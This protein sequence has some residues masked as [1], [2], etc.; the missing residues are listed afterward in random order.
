MWCRICKSNSHL[1]TVNSKIIL[2]KKTSKCRGEL[3]LYIVPKKENPPNFVLEPIR[4]LR[5]CWN[6][7][8]SGQIIT[9]QCSALNIWNMWLDQSL[10]Y[11]CTTGVV[12]FSYITIPTHSSA[13]SSQ[14]YEDRNS[15]RWK[16]NKCTSHHNEMEYVIADKKSWIGSKLGIR[17]AG[18]VKMK[19]K[20]K[21]T[22]LN[23]HFTRCQLRN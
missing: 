8:R 13:Y 14:T 12:R 3:M 20:K 16:H 19:P 18:L 15:T 7:Q 23:K 11:V 5:A 22:K 6:K 21:L 1:F 9:V 10:L 2:P 4:L 17:K